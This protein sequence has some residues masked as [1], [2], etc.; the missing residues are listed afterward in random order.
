MSAPGP[1]SP[2]AAIGSRDAPAWQERARAIEDRLSDALHDRITQRFVDQRSAVL[3]RKLAAPGELLASVS[4]S[5]EVKVEGHYVGKLEG[6]R[7]HPDL[8]A[9]GEAAKTLLAAA[10]RVLRGEIARLVALPGTG[11]RLRISP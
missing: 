1:T 4:A 6:F 11:E 8:A 9:S 7:F 3:V 10:Q 2:I 5:G